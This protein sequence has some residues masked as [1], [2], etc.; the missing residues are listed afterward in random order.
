[1]ENEFESISKD[2]NEHREHEQ[3]NESYV[4]VYNFCEIE[5]IL[6]NHSFPN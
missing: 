2:S 3:G 1:M 5:V 4:K 6:R